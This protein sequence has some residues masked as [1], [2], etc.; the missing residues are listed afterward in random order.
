MI[1]TIDGPAGTGKTTVA[2]RL[3]DRLGFLYFDTG[4]MYR[5]LT[6]LW[7]KN[8]LSLDDGEALKNLI[9][10]FEF[11]IKQEGEI[12]KYFVNKIEV[13]EE[14]RSP[15]ITK[16]V[17]MIA[18]HP[19][20][21]KSLVFI[22]REFGEKGD[23]VFEGRDMGTVVFPRAELKIF[24]T[25]NAEI[26]AHRRYLELKEKF[27]LLTEEK[28]LFENNE[29]DHLDITREVSPLKKAEDA[30]EIDTSLTSIDQVVDIILSYLP[31]GS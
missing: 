30:Y 29:R 11:V 5:A 26:R 7:L 22:Q 16:K 10:S 4:A 27:P 2:K 18:S 1:I 9:H 19:L 20:V 31:K 3:A 24:L 8:P 15:E 14:I 12:K 25:A 6:C 23:A 13:T 21:R 28:I 17:S